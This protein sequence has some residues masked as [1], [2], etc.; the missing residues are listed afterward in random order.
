MSIEQPVIAR[1]PSAAL[2]FGLT[3]K[4]LLLAGVLI[5]CV[6][7]LYAPTL[8]DQ[9]LNYDDDV[10]V[11][12]NAHV[13]K[14]LTSENLGWA[15]TSTSDAGLWQPVTWVSHM[16]DVSVFGMNPAGHH[17]TSVVLHVVNVT[18]LFV[19]LSWMT[20][21]AGLS[22]VVAA[23]FAVHPLNVENVAWIAERKTL[24][25]M[26]FTLLTFAAY[27]RYAR[28]P[29][30][31][32]Y[33][34]VLALFA[35]ALMAKPMAVTVPALLLLQDWWPLRRFACAPDAGDEFVVPKQSATRLIA[36]KIPM[37]PISAVC[38]WI[39]VAAQSH[40]GA[41][42][43]LPLGQRIA[44]SVWSYPAYIGKV[45][46]PGNLAI[47]YP[48]AAA[49][50]PAW[51][52]ALAAIILLLITAACVVCRTQ[53]YLAT[54]F[55]FYLAAML[56]VI[57]VIQAG[58]QSLSDH[59][60]YVPEIGLFI[61][62]VWGGR[63]LLERLKVSERMQ[64]AVALTVVI[65]YATVTAAYLPT[66]K[67][68]Y[69]VFAKAERVSAAPDVLIENNLAQGLAELG[70]H[71]EAVP[72]YRTG[73]AL[74]PAVALPHYNLGNSLLATGKT[75]DAIAEFQTA[76]R[77]S[78]EAGLTLHCLHNMGAAYA[79]A[80]N[81]TE[82]D[83]AYSA[84]LAMAPESEMT[85]LGRGYARLRAGRYKD[86]SEDLARAAKRSPGPVAF[87]LL[88]KALAGE[89]LVEQAMAAQTEALRLAP[90]MS[91]AKEELQRLKALQQGH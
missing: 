79:A 89:G 33:A 85:L 53:R 27:G 66:W 57:G 5:V 6:L 69:T 54:G 73:I 61:A 15:F 4:T 21:S 71:E 39:T 12:A 51:Q 24:L 60:L 45:I 78:R 55:L 68:S 80:E 32:R 31:G 41:V 49:S 16:L 35:L 52:V 64:I 1:T 25:S 82:A 76:L 74:A 2:P 22:L 63:S 50:D 23:L 56:P 3:R 59:F 29:S 40:S 18:L 48:Q 77:L 91:E 43:K 90:E 34:L 10:Y 7:V 19:V 26:M 44:H 11:T 62:A 13:S 46:A 83:K 14:G 20:G 67:N 87:H 42:T 75:A 72:H 9:F 17:A 30:G 70:R 47:M 36:E 58:H 81:W 28:R 88:G 65:G 84:A 37:L 86:A 38:A 8:G